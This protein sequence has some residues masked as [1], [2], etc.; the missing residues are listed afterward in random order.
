MGDP[1]MNP[2]PNRPPED[3]PPT[4][5]GSRRTRRSSTRGA[6]RRMVTCAVFAALSVVVLGLGTILEIMDMTSAAVAAMIVLLIFLCYGT[7][8]ALLTYAVTGVLGVVLMPQS[9]ATWTY[10]GL[11]G[12]YPVIK[13]K[14]D[15]LPKLVGWLFK[16]VLFAAVMALCLLLFH[17]LVMGGQGSLTDSFLAIFDEEEG[18]TAMA[19][20][21]LGLSLFTFVIFDFLLDRLIF[22]YR[23]RFYRQVE[24]W[25]KP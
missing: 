23:V 8:Y 21:I 17:F 2:S 10:L 3:R 1:A 11:M 22:L 7:R 24:K 13:Q 25:M 9:L 4:G 18:K 14:L 6:T 5:N 16:L 19:W 12:Y 15:R 20:A